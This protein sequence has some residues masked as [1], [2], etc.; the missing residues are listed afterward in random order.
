MV[1]RVARELTAALVRYVETAHRLGAAAVT[2]VAT[3]PLRRAR[4]SAT[5]MADVV[6]ATGQPL[7]VISHEEEA[8]LTLLGVTDGR[9]VSA[10]LGVIDVGGGSS[11]VA[12][13]APGRARLRRAASAVGSSRLTA[14]LVEHDPP[15][16]DEIAGA[17]GARR[18]TADREV[19]RRA[20][21]AS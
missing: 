21:R 14:R 19:R 13:V 11:E 15:T 12:F 1:R 5:A 10:E 9:R 17:A 6:A 8:L 4:D 2:I 7:H 18:A 16:R 20:R 3:E